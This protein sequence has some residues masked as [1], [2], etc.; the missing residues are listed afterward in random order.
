[1]NSC[2]ACCNRPI[3][4]V[5]SIVWRI[6]SSGPF[7]AV[8]P[9]AAQKKSR[10]IVRNR[11]CGARHNSITGEIVW[12]TLRASAS[13][14]A[15]YLF[16]RRALAR[17]SVIRYLASNWPRPPRR[18]SLS[19]NFS[20]PSVRQN[21]ADEE[22][23]HRVPTVAGEHARRAVVAGDDQHVGLE[24]GDSRARRR[25]TLRCVSPWRR[26]CRLRRCCRCT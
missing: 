5:N 23:R 24:R 18:Q 11:I 13:Y 19:P 14:H 26:S 3:T 21:L 10:K 15:P 8:R 22:R 12:P 1:M 17:A 20:Q 16:N 9:T 7:D 4:I 6:A 25:R 2:Q